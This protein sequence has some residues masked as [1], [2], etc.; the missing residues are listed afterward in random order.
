MHRIFLILFI[1]LVSIKAIGNA[2]TNYSVDSLRQECSDA[3][4]A[5]DYAKSK[6]LASILRKIAKEKGDRK[7]YGYSNFYLGSSYIFTGKG[8]E[9]EKYLKEAL[10][11]S[12]NIR[13]DSLTGLTLNTLGIYE[14][15]VKNKY[16][17]GQ[18]YFL[19]SLDYPRIEGS[20]YSNL[21]Q[22][23]RLRR[24]TT[25]MEYAQKCYDYG[26]KHNDPHYIYTGL[27]ALAEFNIFKGEYD[28]ALRR[29]NQ[30]RAAAQPAGK[31]S[32]RLDVLNGVVLSHLNQTGKS[33]GILIPLED[34]VLH[35]DPINLS[36]LQLVV[37]KNYEKEGDH[38]NAI[39]WLKKALASAENNS[40]YDYAGMINKMLSDNY[41]SS[42]NDSEALEYM[43]RAYE[44]SEKGMQ[45]DLKSLAAERDLTVRMME[46]ERE[47]EIAIKD[48]RHS[49]VIIFFLGLILII[50]IAAVVYTVKVLRKRNALYRHIVEQ[51][52]KMI[53]EAEKNENIINSLQQD[54]AV[55][56]EKKNENIERK[57]N[58]TKILFE[59]IQKLMKEKELYKDPMLTREKVI[60]L[61]STNSTYLTQAIKEHANMN[62]AQYLNSF[63]VEAAVKALSDKNKI[64]ISIRQISEA[65]GFNSLTTFYKI[66][67]QNIG[68]SPSSY[69]KSLIKINK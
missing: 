53:S 62:Y 51:N 20:V 31:S 29:I 34:S 27:V 22:L 9:G 21:S 7:N 4:A 55:I 59:E 61:L 16:Y 35:R 39:V 18:H 25:G 14:A 26:V 66:F 69:R 42:G 36:E 49:R 15:S 67:Q 44:Y 40:W 19:R 37:G 64:D 6:H 45:A 60:E 47:R 48:A 46:K 32:L 63:R 24:D 52:L 56:N 57:G 28:E 17:L 11:E 58:R 50:A 8:K 5:R 13:C 3:M 43:N 23:A 65:S 2:G 30:A 33:N 1:S 38:H 12:E 41:R 54:L 10:E 68:M